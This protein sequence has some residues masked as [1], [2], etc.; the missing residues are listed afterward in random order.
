MNWRLC[1]EGRWMPACIIGKK[2]QICLGFRISRHAIG[3]L[4]GDSACFPWV[5]CF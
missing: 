5:M 3:L 2:E 4:Y 1:K